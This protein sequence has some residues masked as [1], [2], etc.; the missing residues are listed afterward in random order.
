MSK[1]VARA[2]NPLNGK[3]NMSAM[4]KASKTKLEFVKLE[5]WY[6]GQ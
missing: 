2:L 3:L 4:S 5:W 1:A 6:L